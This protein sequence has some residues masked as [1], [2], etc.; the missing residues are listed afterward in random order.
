MDLTSPA[1]APLHD[2]YG[3]LV[4]S[5]GGASVETVIIDGRVL[6]ERGELLGMNVSAT[7]TELDRR[8]NAL[9]RM[10]LPGESIGYA[11]VK[12]P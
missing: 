4:Y 5:S 11:D 3:S 12:W 7:V 2:I 9:A 8:A 6:V 10:S 1:L